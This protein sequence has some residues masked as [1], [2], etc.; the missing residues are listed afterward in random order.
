MALC[1]NCSSQTNYIC[2]SC[3]KT[4]CNK[5]AECSVPANEETPGWKMGVSVAFCLPC[6]K[7][8]QGSDNLGGQG[9]TKKPLAKETKFP[10]VSRNAK[11][12]STLSKEPT[13]G[14]K[15]L[16]L[17]EKVEVIQ[18]SGTGG[19]SARKLGQ[20]WMWQDTNHKGTKKQ[21]KNHVRVEF[22]RELINAK[23]I[24]QRE[25]QRR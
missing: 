17:R 16:T 11:V 8:K 9:S 15:C 24:K 1:V 10:A 25:V 5:S 4:I 13:A 19:I 20:I 12:P 2:L 3:N 7:R 21:T 18:L 14:R 22:Q 6:S 23:E